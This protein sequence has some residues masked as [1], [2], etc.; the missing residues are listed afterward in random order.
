[1]Y[2]LF[3]L[4]KTNL[5]IAVSE[6][7]TAIDASVV[8]PSPK[9]FSEVTK[10]IKN[11]AW[12]LGAKKLRGICGG[13]AAPLVPGTSRVAS[14]GPRWRDGSLAEKLK[15]IF[16]V[17]VTVENDAALAGLGEAVYGAGKGHDIVAYMTVSTGVG[18]S[19]I[20]HKRIDASAFGF[21]P[22]DQIIDA[23]GKP[24]QGLEEMIAG[25]YFEKRHGKKPYEITD[26]KIWDRAAFLLAC[27]LVNVTALWSP[28][29]IILGGSMMKKVGIPLPKTKAYFD[30]LWRRPRHKPRIVPARLADESGLYGALAYIR[31]KK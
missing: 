18:G 13:I 4:G 14:L 7:G 19:R 3:D 6:R 16:K 21:E 1:M 28:D 22:G 30:R 29:V 17:P 20:T 27:G 10:A 15:T 2:L 31:Q 9:T 26:R 11:G 12:Y 5:R 24:L 25:K 8:V 23:H